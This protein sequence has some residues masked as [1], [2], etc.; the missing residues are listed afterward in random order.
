M[1]MEEKQ[2]T[3]QDDLNPAARWTRAKQRREELQAKVGIVAHAVGRGQDI[4]SPAMPL[5]A[6]AL[7]ELEQLIK[8]EEVAYAA[9]TAW[10]SA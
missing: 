1:T 8:D 3:G 9:Y 6:E 10:T 5:T 7:D 2:P 4:P